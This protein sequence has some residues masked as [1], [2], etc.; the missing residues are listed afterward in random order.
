MMDRNQS[1]PSFNGRQGNVLKYD[2]TKAELDFGY[3]LELS[4]SIYR[5]ADLLPL[6]NQMGFTN[7]NTLE[8]ML[9]THKKRYEREK[10]HLLCFEQS[11]TFCNPLNVVQ[12]AWQNRS[13]GRA[14]YS[15]E[16]L[17]RMFMEGYRV[18]VAAY[19]GMRPNACHQLAELEFFKT[20]EGVMNGE[21]ESERPVRASSR[22]KALLADDLLPGNGRSGLVSIIILNLNG[23]NHIKECIEGVRN[24]TPPIY[25]IIG[26][27]NGST[28]ESLEYLRSLSEIKLIENK[29]NVGAPYGRNQGLALA[30][31]EYIVFLDNDTVVT[32]GWLERF[33][34]CS[35]VNP[36]FGLLG[37]M[38][39]YVSGPQL[40]ENAQYADFNELQGFARKL[41]QKNAG[42]ASCAHRLILFC[43]FAKREVI[44]KIGG[45]DA[46]FRK[47]GFEDDDFCVRAQIAGYRLVIV[48][49][50][51]V[52]HTGSQTARTSNM[53]Y[54]SLMNENWQVFR[55][56]WRV[57]WQPGQPMS[58]RIDRII[59]Q[60]FDSDRHVVSIPHRD[61]IEKLLFSPVNS[62]SHTGAA[63]NGHLLRTEGRLAEG[64]RNFHEGRYEQAEDLFREVIRE[65]PVSASAHND[66]ACLLWQTDRTEEALKELTRAMEIDTD[67]R[68]TVWNLG[69][70]L[71]SMGLIQDARHIYES[72]IER[73][74]GEQKMSD[75][76]LQWER[77]NIMRGIQAR[78]DRH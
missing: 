21:W 41:S 5:I 58:Y 46:G 49:D 55:Q 67:N 60:P 37:P 73:H 64:E 33:I 78:P 3:P 22:N 76:L 57:D 10:S 66:L 17:A 72:Y 2:W 75:A 42:K 63:E 4:S 38:S 70:I 61:K 11:V 28:D 59:A 71:Q 31:G 52:H 39:N 50:V 32:E 65:D 8:F 47:W 54:D 29:E 18:D 19:S 53:D 16:R 43:L 56:K 68:D 69:Q 35:K 36:A 7:P 44:K 1:L 25:E 34:A 77:G 6:L 62:P 15:S 13:G 51:Y 26:V 30:E 40:L 27:D 12:T 20:G 74:P 48:K 14:E 24:C 23:A 9:D 45:F